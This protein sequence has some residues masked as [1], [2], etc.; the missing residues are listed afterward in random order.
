MMA[1]A[2]SWNRLHPH[3]SST[4]VPVPFSDLVTFENVFFH[5]EPVN[6]NEDNEGIEQ[7]TQ[8]RNQGI[9]ALSYRDWEVWPHMTAAA[10]F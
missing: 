9:I 2:F 3:H 4:S 7:N 1:E 6:A 5:T 8:M 10:W